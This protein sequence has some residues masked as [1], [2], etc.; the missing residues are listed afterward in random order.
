MFS[1]ADLAHYAHNCF[2][3]IGYPI[4]TVA[5]LKSIP[6]HHLAN[7]LAKASSAHSLRRAVQVYELLEESTK[8]SR[9][10]KVVMPE[11]TMVVS[12]MSIA[13][14]VDIN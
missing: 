13:Q 11:E 6:F 5:Q 1:G 10:F 4:F 2:T 9:R 12:N 8:H 14:I 7:E 3:L